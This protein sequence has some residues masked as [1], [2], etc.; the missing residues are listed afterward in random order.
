MLWICE[1]SMFNVAESCKFMYKTVWSPQ[2]REIILTGK[3]NKRLFKDNLDTLLA[4]FPNIRSIK[5]V[6]EVRSFVLV[7]NL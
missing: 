5:Y 3:T 2:R 6:C 4:K 7:F 1:G